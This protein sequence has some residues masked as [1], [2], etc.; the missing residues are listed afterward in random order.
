MFA[1]INLSKSDSVIQDT[2]FKLCLKSFPL[3]GSS[4]VIVKTTNSSYYGNL[5]QQMNSYWSIILITKEIYTMGNHS[6]VSIGGYLFL[7]GNSSSSELMNWIYILKKNRKML[8]NARAAFILVANKPDHLTI[9]DRVTDLLHEIKLLNVLLLIHF[10]S[11]MVKGF[12]WKN[13]FKRN[14]ICGM[15]KGFEPIN[16]LLENPFPN[17]IPNNWKGCKFV[18]AS[19]PQK[20]Y[21]MDNNTNGLEIFQMNLIGDILDMKVEYYYSEPNNDWPILLSRL[22]NENTTQLAL[23]WIFPNPGRFEAYDFLDSH[24]FEPIV[25]FIPDRRIIPRWMSLFVVFKMGVWILTFTALLIVSLLFCLLHKQK[26]LLELCY[27]VID[28]FGVLLNISIPGSYNPLLYF[29]WLITAFLINLYYQTFLMGFMT[30]PGFLPILKSLEEIL[31]KN[32]TMGIQ[33]VEFFMY[34]FNDSKYDQV[35]AQFHRCVFLPPCMQRLIDRGDMVIAHTK[36]DIQYYYLTEFKFAPFTTTKNKILGFY[37]SPV[38]AKDSIFL[39]KFNRIIGKINEAG[40]NGYLWGSMLEKHRI[41]VQYNQSKRLI[42][43]EKIAM[44]SP[45]NFTNLQS[46]FSLL[47]TCYLFCILVFLGE[48][49]FHYVTNLYKK[50]KKKIDYKSKMSFSNNFHYR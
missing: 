46:A 37:I 12:T 22:E 47:I 13:V 4:L 32:I 25:W 44:I 11:N 31:E 9:E 45:L 30:D 38:L 8:W 2:I 28:L 29:F 36:H 1:F 19:L 15:S 23:G 27:I 18:V 42:K 39:D 43:K 48:H 7:I 40:L 24:F 14:E 34:S 41:E 20:P 17:R 33:S 35:L 16:N 10:E 49:L 5:I 50:K 26:T 21:V 6:Q 3:I